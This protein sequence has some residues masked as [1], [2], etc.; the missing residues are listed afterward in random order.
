MVVHANRNDANRRF[1]ATQQHWIQGKEAT[2]RFRLYDG[3]GDRSLPPC[4][5]AIYGNELGSS[6]YAIDEWDNCLVLDIENQNTLNNVKRAFHLDYNINSES[7]SPDVMILSRSEPSELQDS[8][9]EDEDSTMEGNNPNNPIIMC[10]ESNSIIELSKDS[11]EREEIP[12]NRYNPQVSYRKTL[13][14]TDVT[15]SRLYLGASFA[16]DLTLFGHGSIWQIAGLSSSEGNNVFFFHL[17]KSQGRN[18]ECK[19]G[20]DWAE[21]CQTYNLK[22]NDTIILKMDSL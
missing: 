16:A 17:L 14:H 20:V 21:C 6:C 19:F 13:T 18:T 12:N 3:Q 2:L 8:S 4:F 11:S 9:D 7:S 22:E 1:L 15:G 10:V 5:E